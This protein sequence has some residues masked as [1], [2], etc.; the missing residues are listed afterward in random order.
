MNIKKIG[1]IVAVAIVILGASAWAFFTS[2]QAPSDSTAKNADTTAPT[3]RL[4]VPSASLELA[5]TSGLI[6]IS[7]E[8]SDDTMIDRVEYLLDGEVVQRT[9][10]PP[11]RASISTAGLSPGKHTLQAVAYDAAGNSGKSKVFT[12]IIEQTAVKPADDISEGIITSSTSITKS[13]TTAR[14]AGSSTTTTNQNPPSSGGGST[15]PQEPEA[16]TAGG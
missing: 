3:I 12:F 5:K 15:D 6:E 11:Y 8:T 13:K 1:I 10:E 9:I 14:T 16:R 7:V 4:N 2:Q